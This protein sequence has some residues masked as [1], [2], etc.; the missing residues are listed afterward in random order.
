MGLN[1]GQKRKTT[2]VCHFCGAP[3]YDICRISVDDRG[4]EQSVWKRQPHN[5]EHCV[6]YLRQ[7]VTQL[8]LQNARLIFRT[9]PFGAAQRSPGTGAV[10]TLH[11]TVPAPAPLVHRPAFEDI[12][13][14]MESLPVH[15]RDDESSVRE[16]LI[17]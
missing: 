8:Q 14:V 1:D 12:P 6:L 17:K 3:L 2:A 5:R 15:Y 9:I 11:P 4:R 13:V 10:S 16:K 7:Q